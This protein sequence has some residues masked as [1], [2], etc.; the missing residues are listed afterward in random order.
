MILTNDNAKIVAAC[1][2]GSQEFEKVYRKHNLTRP[3]YQR[4]FPVEKQAVMEHKDG[5]I[6]VLCG[7]TKQE[8][9]HS[10]LSEFE[11]FYGINSF[12]RTT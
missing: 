1:L 9:I 2:R 3:L 5:S 8:E 11:R 7:V 12:K 10:N 6:L 4:E